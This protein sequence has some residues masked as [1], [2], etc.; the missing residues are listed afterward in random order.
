MFLLDTDHL[1]ILQQRATPES[2]RLRAR[3]DRHPPDA[4]FVS[5]VS[6]HEQVAGWNAYMNAAKDRDGVVRAYRMFEQ[7]LVDFA[8]GRV[9]SFDPS[10]ADVFDAL[11]AARVRIGTMDLRIAAI[12][13]ANDKTV[14]TRNLS[15]FRKVPALRVEDWTL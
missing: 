1:G 7:I 3:M 11:R 6:F 8:A 10:A 14:L 5:V 15:D 13:L 4:F 12:A 9:L 2:G